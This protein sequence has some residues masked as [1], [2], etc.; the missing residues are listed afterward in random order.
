[1]DDSSVDPAPLSR[2]APSAAPKPRPKGSAPELL[3]YLPKNP[4]T[5]PGVIAGIFAFELLYGLLL[6]AVMSSM[7]RPKREIVVEIPEPVQVT[8]NTTQLDRALSTSSEL[9]AEEK[10]RKAEEKAKLEAEQAKA[11]AKAEAEEAKR[12]KAEGE[13]KAKELKE[14]EERE[15]AERKRQRE[16]E[17]KKRERSIEQLV[18]DAHKPKA[19]AEQ[20]QVKDEKTIGPLGGLIDPNMDCKTIPEDNVLIVIVPDGLHALSPELKLTNSP[21]ALTDYAGDFRTEVTIGGAINPGMQAIKGL[22]FAYQGAGLLIWLDGNNYVRLERGMSFIMGEGRKPQILVENC[23]DGVTN[24]PVV[25]FLKNDGSIRL[26]IDRKGQEIICSF[27][28]DS[29]NA[30]PE[31]NWVKIKQFSL[32][33]PPAVEIGISASNVS[34]KVYPARF[35]N[36]KLEPLSDNPVLSRAG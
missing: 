28:S 7:E 32:V 1:V 22:P 5:S 14:K 13:R 35:E 24:N 29:N 2:T 16:A 12:K 8:V 4:L 10:A 17:R 15:K 9:T 34:L 20:V 25:K 6:A 26:R 19:Q 36:F 30:F 18:A 33:L 21:R 31:T 23:K 11:R 3:A 27:N